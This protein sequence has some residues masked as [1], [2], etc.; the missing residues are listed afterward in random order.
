MDLTGIILGI[1]A[2]NVATFLAGCALALYRYLAE[3]HAD[4][5]RPQRPPS[6]PAHGRRLSAAKRHS[7]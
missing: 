6:L 1:L 7:D 5:V 4:A 2:L 3:Q